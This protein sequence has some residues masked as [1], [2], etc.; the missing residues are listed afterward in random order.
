MS[1][2]TSFLGTGSY[3]EVIQW[4]EFLI[5]RTFNCKRQILMLHLGKFLY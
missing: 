3:H 2:T 5:T 4:S 1:S